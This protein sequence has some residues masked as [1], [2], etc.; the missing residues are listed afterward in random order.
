MRVAS[1]RASLGRAIASARSEASAS[2]G[3]GGIYLEK[4]LKPIRHVE[5][6]IMADCFGN[7]IHIGERDCSV[8]RRHQKL[9]E[10]AP[11]PA[12]SPE[13]RKQMGDAAVK[14]AKAIGYEGAHVEFILPATSFTSWK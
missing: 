14:A 4:Y 12:I 3:D 7:C 10:E 2:F 13:L 6:Q 8:Q 9:I 1:D 11:S 5:I